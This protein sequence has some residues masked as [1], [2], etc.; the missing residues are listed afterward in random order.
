VTDG[1]VV[2]T[3]AVEAVPDL[4]SLRDHWWWR[5]G[6]APGHRMLAWHLTFTGQH[7]LHAL[8]AQYQRALAPFDT[9]DPVP[10]RWLHLTVADIG[11]AAAV[12]ESALPALEA[13]VRTRVDALPPLELNVG[14]VVLFAESV[15]LAPEPTDAVA[16][17]RDAVL[18]SVAEVLGDAA[19][20]HADGFVPHLSLA[21]VNAAERSAPVLD[22]L[23]SVDAQA[24]GRIRPTLALIELHR[25]DRQYEWQVRA[26]LRA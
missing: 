21:Y 4:D 18:A 24:V 20:A 10:S 15:V 8:A 5:P 23:R 22:A 6:W 25:D 19:P 12:P 17:V 7:A 26:A 11:P 2:G 3:V 13:A 16:A 9:L 1:A 14:R